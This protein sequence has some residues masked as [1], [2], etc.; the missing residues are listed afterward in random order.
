MYY[1]YDNGQ[2]I[3]PLTVEQLKNYNLSLQ[4]RIWQEGQPNWGKVQDFP[5]IVSALSLRLSD[6]KPEL[7]WWIW[8]MAV[9]MPIITFQFYVELA[10]DYD[11]V[12]II[13]SAIL[14]VFTFTYYISIVLLMRRKYKIAKILAIVGCSL[15]V[16]IGMLGM[17]GVNKAIDKATT[18]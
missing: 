17:V 5:E 10:S 7:N 6:Q 14:L 1:I 3:G 2:Q 9:I 18:N 13:F 16:P 11:N 8:V 12:G 4:S 15:F